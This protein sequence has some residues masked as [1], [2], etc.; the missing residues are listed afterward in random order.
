MGAELVAQIPRAQPETADGIAR[1]R[2]LRCVD[3]APVIVDAAHTI[4]TAAH[5]ER[6]GLH[7]SAHVAQFAVIGTRYEALAAA[8]GSAVLKVHAPQRQDQHAPRTRGVRLR[9]HRSEL[10]TQVR[11]ASAG[12]AAQRCSRFA[13]IEHAFPSL[14]L[15]IYIALTRQ[16]ARLCGELFG[17]VQLVA[18]GP[19]RLRHVAGGA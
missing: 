12:F 9:M 10:G 15:G 16:V 4:R 5:L 8:I 6:E 17:R 11:H 18:T 7:R 1:V 14:Q 19:R 2:A 13:A 3:H